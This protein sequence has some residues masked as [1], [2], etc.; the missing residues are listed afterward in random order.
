MSS[1]LPPPSLCLG[2]TGTRAGMTQEQKERV[3]DAVYNRLRVSPPPFAVHGDCVG[4]DDYF[5]EVC[6]FFGI[7]R[8]I[9]PSDVPSLRAGCDRKHPPAIVLHEPAPPLVRNRWIA[10]ACERIIAT[11][12]QMEE[13]KRS[14]T[15]QC[16]RV[17]RHTNRTIL[18]IWPDGSERLEGGAW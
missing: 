5:D 12:G 10:L 3:R 15:S 17:A 14:G 8:G 4:A 16:I 18:T 13:R 1:I 2:F 6:I 7:G 9:Y 11:P